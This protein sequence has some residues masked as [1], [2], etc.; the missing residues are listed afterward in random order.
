MAYMEYTLSEQRCLFQSQNHKFY[1]VIIHKIG[2]GC[3][4]PAHLATLICTLPD[5]PPIFEEFVAK[6]ST[7]I[8]LFAQHR[9]ILKLQ[10]A[11]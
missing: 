7:D 2:N 1:L 10:Q 4:S 5:L 3:A 11:S 9:S 8:L 6:F